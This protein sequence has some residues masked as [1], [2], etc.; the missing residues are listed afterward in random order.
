MGPPS[1]ITKTWGLA[2]GGEQWPLQSPS[3]RPDGRCW[4]GRWVSL[5]GWCL[6]RGRSAGPSCAVQVEL[7][8]RMKTVDRRE[9]N[10]EGKGLG[11]GIR[12]HLP[13]FR[14]LGLPEWPR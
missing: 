11:H 7:G 1:A 9:R 10:N 2:L 12:S 4:Q 14:A 13:I 8:K 5:R 6:R 3:L